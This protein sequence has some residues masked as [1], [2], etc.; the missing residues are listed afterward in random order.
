MIAVLPDS[1]SPTRGWYSSQIPCPASSNLPCAAIR[2]AASCST[3]DSIAHALPAPLHTWASTRKTVISPDRES[4]SQRAGA[5]RLTLASSS[6]KNT[7]R[8]YAI[9]P[10]CP[11]SRGTSVVT[12]VRAWNK[13]RADHS[14]PPSPAQDQGNALSR[15]CHLPLIR[16]QMPR[17]IL[18][19]HTCPELAAMSAPGRAR[20]RPSKTRMLAS[21]AST[22]IRLACR[23]GDTACD[24]I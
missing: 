18:T 23:D 8:I 7:R 17:Q 10:P 21:K 9:T 1:S 3:L 6:S 20:R 13:Q 24:S 14:I 16:R 12:A 22:T 4:L 5:T 2:P 11:R 19:S 15:L